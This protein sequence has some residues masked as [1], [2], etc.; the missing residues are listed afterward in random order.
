MNDH[1]DHRTEEAGSSTIPSSIKITKRHD[2]SFFMLVLHSIIRPLKGR[3]VKLQDPLPAGSPKLEASKRAL[4]KVDVHERIVEDIRVYD[5]RPKRSR[6]RKEEKRQVVKK[7][8]YYFCGGGWRSPATG[9]H[10]ALLTEMASQLPDTQVSLVSYPL[11]PKSPAPQT[12]PKLMRLYREVMRKAHEAGEEVILAGDSA[13]GN[14]VLSIIVSALLEDAEK[15][16]ELPCAKAIFA[17]CPSTDLRRQ[18]PDMDA[19][20]AWDPLLR[21]AFIKDTAK[22]W[23]GDWDP[24]DIRVSPILGDLTPLAKRGVPVHGMTGGWDILGPDAILFREA[25]AKAGV[26]GEWLEWDKQMHCWPS[27][28][29]FRVRES[30]AAKDWMVDVLRRV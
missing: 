2:R 6:T 29:S 26:R 28:F 14:I 19:L 22:S 20:E 11:A 4:K 24:S 3:V 1:H 23:C 15:G 18:N 17:M 5:L 8:I 21:I 27:A 25:C 9:E 7:R 13:G 10:W 16:E 12:F 30:V